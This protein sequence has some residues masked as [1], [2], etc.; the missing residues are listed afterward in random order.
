MRPQLRA[1]G[2]ATAVYLLALG[3]CAAMYALMAVTMFWHHGTPSIWEDVLGSSALVLSVVF[4]IWAA[5]STY[6]RML[7]PDP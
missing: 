3:A 2:V 1:V 7:Q 5:A 4:P 6:R